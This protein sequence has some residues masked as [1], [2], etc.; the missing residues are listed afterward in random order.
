MGPH[1][2]LVC[3]D[4]GY[5]AAID[6]FFNRGGNLLRNHQTLSLIFVK[7]EDRGTELSAHTTADALIEIDLY[8]HG[9][10]ISL[11]A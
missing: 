2:R 4:R 9:M 5:G 1:L 6:R 3:R 10:F 7:L 8:S 11:P